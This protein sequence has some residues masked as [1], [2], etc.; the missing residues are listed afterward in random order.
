MRRTRIRGI[1]T[2]EI[3][4]VLAIVA[5]LAGLAA[6][7]WRGLAQ[8]EEARSTL[9]SLQQAMWQGAT[10]AAARGQTL[11]LV[12]EEDELRVV[13][14]GG[15]VFRA[16]SFPDATVTTLEAG[17]IVTFSPPGRIADLTVLPD[18]LTMVV[19]DR[20]ASLEVSLIGET[21]VSW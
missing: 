7:G 15:D 6:A 16:W 18:P 14:A 21:E 13:D 4:V 1:S 11:T 19:N 3:L 12:W 2:L 17:D 10:A 20:T 5:I 8:R 9:V